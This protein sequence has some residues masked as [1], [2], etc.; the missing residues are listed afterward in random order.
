[1]AWPNTKALVFS[2]LTCRSIVADTTDYISGLEQPLQ[3]IVV[4]GAT[5]IRLESEEQH[6]GEGA[7]AGR[8]KLSPKMFR[9]GPLKTGWLDRLLFRNSCLTLLTSPAASQ[10]VQGHFV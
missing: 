2:C 8:C 7:D 3:M 10:H 9:R 1:M 6:S 5:G 4:S